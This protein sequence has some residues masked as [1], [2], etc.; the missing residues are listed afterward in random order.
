MP[1]KP[2]EP[3]TFT[4]EEWDNFEMEGRMMGKP[5]WSAEEWERMCK[6]GTAP[7]PK[8]DRPARNKINKG[9]RKAH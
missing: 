1:K 9:A 8:P 7:N 5:L 2:K 4:Q 3:E 6:T